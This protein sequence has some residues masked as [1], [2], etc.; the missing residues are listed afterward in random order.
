M[1]YYYFQEG[2]F[3]GEQE[4]VVSDEVVLRLLREK[5]MTLEEIE[6]MCI[7]FSKFAELLG[8]YVVVEVDEDGETDRYVYHCSDKEFE[9]YRRSY[10]PVWV[11]PYA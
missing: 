6:E 7:K 5:R 2:V 1:N 3:P 11:N 4:L 9:D 10:T 8:D